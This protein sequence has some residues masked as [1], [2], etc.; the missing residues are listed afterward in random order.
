MLGISAKVQWQWKGQTGDQALAAAIDQSVKNIRNWKPFFRDFI[1]IVLE[2][3][4]AEQFLT[5]GKSGNT[6]WAPLAESTI[7]RRTRGGIRGSLGLSGGFGNLD[8]LRRTNRMYQSFFGG[9]DHVQKMTNQTLTWGTSVPYA[10]IHQTGARAPSQGS[11]FA[12]RGKKAYARPRGAQGGVIPA[13][14]I[15]VFSEKMRSQTNVAISRFAARIAND[16]GFKI[17]GVTLGGQQLGFGE[18]GT[19][20]TGTI[21]TQLSLG[22]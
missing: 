4:V 12:H 14:P 22:F 2:P 13:R 17:R 1:Q 8:I 20:A 11:L 16:S 10:P 5:E 6:P 7:A 19:I 3:G 18:I 9:A 21:P 15:L